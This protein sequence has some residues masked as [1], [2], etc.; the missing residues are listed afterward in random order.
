[1]HSFPTRRYSDLSSSRSGSVSLNNLPVYSAKSA[2]LLESL[3]AEGISIALSED[4][5]YEHTC[6]LHTFNLRPWLHHIWPSA[7]GKSSGELAQ[8]LHHSL[9]SEGQPHNPLFDTRS[10]L[11]ALQEFQ[12]GW[13]E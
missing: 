2:G 10:L 1:Q 7:I 5:I 12:H 11:V 3:A 4:V 8:L 9:L 13:F 6:E